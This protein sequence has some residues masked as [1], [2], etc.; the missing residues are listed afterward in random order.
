GVGAHGRRVEAAAGQPGDGE[1]G[2][3]A[4]VARPY[5]T[6]DAARPSLTHAARG[7]PGDALRRPG[8]QLAALEEL[9]E[10]LLGRPDR[11]DRVRSDHARDATPPPSRRTTAGSTSSRLQQLELRLTIRPAACSSSSG[12]KGVSRP[13]R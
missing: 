9:R 5:E 2:V 11:L 7:E 8:H 6:D 3:R 12:E 1:E 4:V 13:R 10:G